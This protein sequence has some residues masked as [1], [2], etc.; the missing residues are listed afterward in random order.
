MSNSKNE[1]F[2]QRLTRLFR[3]GPAIRQK[4]RGIDP[5][6]FYDKS[7]VQN[8]LGYYGAAA[9][10]REVSPFSVMGAYGLLDRMSRYAEFQEMEYTAE[11]ASALDIYADESCAP[12]EDGKC[13]HIY[14]DNR[15]IRNALE[16]LFYE[17][18]NVELDMRYWVR[19]LVKYGDFF[20]YNEVV[21]DQGVIHVEPIPVNI[22]EREEGYDPSDPYAVRFKLLTHGGKILENWQVTHFRLQGN[23]LFHPYGSSL[24]EPA[25][26]TWRQLTML[27]DAMLVYRVVRSPER[28]VFY[29]DVSGIH[30]NDVPTYMEA[31]TQTIKGNSVIDK[32]N[33]RMDFRYNAID[34]NEDYFLPTRP[35]NLTKIETL[36]GG[37]HVSAT[38][39]V[40]YIQKKLFAALKVPRAYLTYDESLSSKATLSQEDIRFSR[41]INT[42]QKVILAELSK[43]AIIHL[44]AK[45]FE[46]ED[47]ID[48]ELKLS[49]PSTVAVQQKLQLL[50]TRLEA[51]AK[52]QEMARES[53]ILSEEWIQK[54]I[55]KLRKDEIL[56][57]RKQKFEEQERFLR[58]Q[59]VSIQD[60]NQKT[61]VDPFDPSNYKKIT[62]VPVSP[63]I[64]KELSGTMQTANPEPLQGKNYNFSIDKSKPPIKANP[65]PNLD[66]AARK[67][68]RRKEFT[69][70]RALAMP[71]F[72]KML[73]A[74]NRYMKDPYDIKS[75]LEIELKKH[76]TKKRALPNV[77]KDVQSM[78]NKFQEHFAKNNQYI[79]IEFI[80]EEDNSITDDSMLTLEDL[81]DCFE[82]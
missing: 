18:A 47:L 60:T 32:M 36:A 14:T 73:S 8:N 19:N 49:N 12:D 17:T 76:G 37:Q 20:L 50:M 2:F 72:N 24:L 23:E 71:D 42:L 4:I 28:R 1:S 57:I 63:E 13:L 74:D 68:E 75:L 53:T 58:L 31:V 35:N 7:V 38:E 41:T 67:R 82:K 55:L 26:R 51:A 52:A 40:E 21:P 34:V 25:R 70:N 5:K 30:P 9:F 29:I 44:F 65:T 16:E 33:G 3:T 80:N 61:I 56:E 66:N 45:G 27:E 10:K 39:D 46:G 77:S 59:K 78:L 11:I 79:D 69:G 48:F 43:L 22:I 54:E 81:A 64:E 6:N 62:G 15:Q